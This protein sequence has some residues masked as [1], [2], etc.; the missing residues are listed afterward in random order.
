MK[1]IRVV[2]DY[3]FGKYGLGT[4]GYCPKNWEVLMFI[5]G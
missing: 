1:G 4:Y 5:K 2:L 3:G